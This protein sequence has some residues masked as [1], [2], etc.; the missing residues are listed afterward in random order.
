MQKR[1]FPVICFFLAFFVLDTLSAQNSDSQTRSFYDLFRSLGSNYKS[2]ALSEGIIRTISKGGSLELS[3]SP[4]SG[5]DLPARILATGSSFLAESLVVIPYN[6]RKLTVLDAYNALGE[7]RSLKGRLYHSS[8]RNQEVALFE[9]AVRLES[10]KKNNPIPDPPPAPILPFKETVYI[11]LKDNNFGNTYYRA[12]ISPQGNGLLYSL[13][14]YRNI[15]Y[16][17]FTV[18]KEEK[19]NA[20][21]YLEPLAEGMLIYSVA[22]TEVSDF[23][24]GMIDVPS[25]ISKRLAVFIDWISDGVGKI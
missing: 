20:F 7:V 12:E 9:D 19:F 10:D 15:S 17:F 16:L 14:N 4:D 5:I 2:E 23:V 3:P 24:S 22:G 25:A 18:M 1:I 6:S 8:T 11:R 13:T 21:L